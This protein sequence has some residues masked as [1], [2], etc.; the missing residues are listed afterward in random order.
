MRMRTVTSFLKKI[1]NVHILAGT[2]GLC[3]HFEGNFFTHEH[4]VSA[5][6]WNPP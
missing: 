4:Y 6:S 3:G 1:Q 5:Q 2:D